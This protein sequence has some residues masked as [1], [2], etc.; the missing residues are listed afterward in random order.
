MK[1]YS[2]ER[3]EAVL[4]KLASPMNLTIPEVGEAE[5]ISMGDHAGAA[6]RFIEE[7]AL[8]PGMRAQLPPDYRQY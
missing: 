4:R 3:K 5:G 6:E 7:V 1:H 8:G 2:A